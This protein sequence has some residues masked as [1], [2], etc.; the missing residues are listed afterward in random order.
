M[1]AES[2]LSL[3]ACW[4]LG[5]AFVDIPGFGVQISDLL[6]ILAQ[7]AA[8]PIEPPNAAAV[9]HAAIA[10]AHICDAQAGSARRLDH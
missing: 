5:M 1:P 8:I 2:S 7:S 9:R 4:A 3:G 10:D 6:G